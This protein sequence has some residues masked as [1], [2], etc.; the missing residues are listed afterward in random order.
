MLRIVEV[1]VCAHGIRCVTS[2]VLSRGLKSFFH[3]HTVGS[4]SLTFDSVRRASSSSLNGAAA[5]FFFFFALA[6]FV[7]FVIRGEAVLCERASNNIF[8]NTMDLLLLVSFGGANVCVC[9]VD[10]CASLNVVCNSLRFMEIVLGI[11][12]CWRKKKEAKNKPKRKMRN[13]IM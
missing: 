2:S 5:V 9:D 4:T 7:P 10:V 6:R 12:F 3:S 13:E 8:S 11:I 1:V